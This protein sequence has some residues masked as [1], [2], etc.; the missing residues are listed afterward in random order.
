[1]FKYLTEKIGDLVVRIRLPNQEGVFPVWL[2][3]HGWTGDE[4]SMWVFESRLPVDAF[5]VAPRGI[6]KS[7][8]GGYGWHKDLGDKWP[9]M[10][11]FQPAINTIND[12]ISTKQFSKA[13]FSQ[14]SMVGFSQG[15]ALAYAFSLEHPVRVAS[16]AALSGF[17]PYD[18]DLTVGLVDLKGMPVYITHGSLDNLVPIDKARFAVEYLTRAGAKVSYCEENVG[19]KLSAACFNGM[20][21]FFNG[22]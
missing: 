17:I 1:M 16:L 15:A 13:D 6:Y 19:H 7:S 18:V 14:L 4:N 12:L 5:V 21:S 9:E 11:Y 2:L 3:L 22:L 8:F 20:E 10:S